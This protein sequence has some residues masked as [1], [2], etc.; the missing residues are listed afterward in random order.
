MQISEAFFSDIK[1]A[2]PDP[3]IGRYIAY[4]NDS[5][6]LK[7]NLVVGAYRD[8]FEKPYVFQVVRK[9]EDE[10]INDPSL[11]KVIK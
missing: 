3:M 10:I 2:P 1:S 5:S 7:M 9:V 4:L 11:D 6:P 8:E